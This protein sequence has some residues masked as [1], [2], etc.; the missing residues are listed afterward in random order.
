MV[1]Y[2][3]AAAEEFPQVLDFI[4][5]VFSMEHSPHN[6]RELLPKLYQQGQEEKTS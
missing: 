6:F 5:M 4:N 2:R 3:K 1:T